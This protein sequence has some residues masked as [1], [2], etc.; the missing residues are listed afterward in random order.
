MGIIIG[1]LIAVVLIMG[2]VL[3]SV[4]HALLEAI[5]DNPKLK[6]EIY[7][8]E[9]NVE[10]KF[11]CML[12]LTLKEGADQEAQIFDFSRYEELGIVA[13]TQLDTEVRLT[14]HC[15]DN[16]VSTMIPDQIICR[17]KDGSYQWDVRSRL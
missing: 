2:L 3:R 5:E 8:D 1:L 6:A 4:W 14:K 9:K 11:P 10:E 15:E 17:M 13:M 12:L 7:F 16:M